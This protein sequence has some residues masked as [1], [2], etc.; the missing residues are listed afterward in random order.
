M[1]PAGHSA[2][3][4]EKWLALGWPL[5]V[6]CV[7]LL[8][9]W[10]LPG[11]LQS[12]FACYGVEAALA[13]PNIYLI[14]AIIRHQLG[15]VSAIWLLALTNLI[16]LAIFAQCIVAA[17]AIGPSGSL[18]HVSVGLADA[19]YFSIVTWTTLGYGDFVPMPAFRLFAA[20]QAIY[21]YV[22]MGVLVG[23]ISGIVG[24]RRT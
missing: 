11:R 14:R 13:F 22:S 10:A 9:A 15:T 2:K 1:P 3:G 8:A 6:L 12:A 4:P 7:L 17:N 18:A 16:S 19:I 5:T 23:L 24:S 21:G 20:I